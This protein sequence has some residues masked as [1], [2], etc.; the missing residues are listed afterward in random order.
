MPSCIY[1]VL[2]IP[3]EIIH[4]VH[5]CNHFCHFHNSTVSLLL[6]INIITVVLT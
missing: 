3:D 4:N 5:Y 6:I 2:L 1:G